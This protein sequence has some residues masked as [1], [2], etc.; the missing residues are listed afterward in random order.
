M[1]VARHQVA[2]SRLHCAITAVLDIERH[3]EQGFAVATEGA[4]QATVVIEPDQAG[5]EA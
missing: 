2:A 1:H 5:G 4:V 3:R